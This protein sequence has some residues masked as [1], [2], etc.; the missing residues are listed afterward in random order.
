MKFTVFCP[1]VLFTLCTMLDSQIVGVQAVPIARTTSS[2]SSYTLDDSDELDLAQWD[3]APPMGAI[4]LSADGE[5]FYLGQIDSDAQDNLNLD[6]DIGM[7]HLAQ[8]RNVKGN[9]KHRNESMS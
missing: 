6:M 3:V 8:L 5:Q 1:A 7:D 2:D 9:K 4:G